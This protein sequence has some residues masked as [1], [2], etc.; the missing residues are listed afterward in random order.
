VRRF[1]IIGAPELGSS[2]RHRAATF[3]WA[4]VD[5]LVRRCPV[6]WAIIDTSSIHIVATGDWRL[7]SVEAL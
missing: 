3:P 7:V 1:R 6:Q 4:T 2:N 5:V